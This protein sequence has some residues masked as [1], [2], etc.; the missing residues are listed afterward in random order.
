[1]KHAYATVSTSPASRRGRILAASLTVVLLLC[2]GAFGALH[3]VS[4]WPFEHPGGHHASAATVPAGAS[5]TDHQM[6]HQAPVAPPA[7]LDHQTGEHVGAVAHAGYA[8]ALFVVLLGAAA[9]ALFFAWSPARSSVADARLPG[10]A[11]ALFHLR[12]PRVPTL[13]LL[14]VFRL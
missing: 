1:M 4:S 13:S 12:S 14:Q 3:Q 6:G 8:A 10:R 2:H 9:L 5:A 11:L 7:L